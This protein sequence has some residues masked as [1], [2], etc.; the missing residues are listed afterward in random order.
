MRNLLVLLVAG[1]ILVAG[2]VAQPLAARG[3]P[4]MPL[5]VTETVTIQ[6]AATEVWARIKRFDGLARWHP[7]FAKSSLVSGASGKV[8]AVRTLTVKDGPTFTEELLEYSE[9]DMTFT[10]RIIESPLPL[11][12]YVSTLSVT[13]GSAAA[14]VRWTGTFKRKNPADSPPT[15]EDDASAIKLIEVVY[16]TGLDHLKKMLEGKATRAL[17]RAVAF[18]EDCLACSSR[19][20]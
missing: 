11:A 17:R 14:V 7:L 16:R 9:A 13:P 8:G 4:R 19:P 5:Q 10:Y 15:G 1:L 3:E 18:C 6:A 20:L 2:P 12:D